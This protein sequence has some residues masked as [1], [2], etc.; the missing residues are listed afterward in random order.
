MPYFSQAFPSLTRA[1]SRALRDSGQASLADQ[2][3]PAVID[4]VTCE[5]S[6]SAAY[7][8]VRPSWKL[9]I[10]EANIIG[11]RHGQTIEVETPYWTYIDID[12]FD[13]L[14]GV[15][16]LAPGELKQELMERAN[17]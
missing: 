16:V 11:V 5:A 14:T 1:L 6:T 2:I 4:R 8:Y 17:G 7:I 10:V 15:E 13:R 12:N 3:E 9:N